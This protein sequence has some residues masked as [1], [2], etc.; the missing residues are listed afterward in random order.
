MTPD[1]ILPDVSP[2]EYEKAGSKFAQAGDHLSECGMPE[3]DTPGVSIKFP[4][5]IVEEGED[6]GKESK[7]SAG[8]GKNALWKLKE[9][10]TALGVKC[11]EVNG[12]VAFD[13]MACVG[14]P[15]V[16]VWT[17]EKDS[18]SPEEGGK[19][20]SYTKPTGALPVGAKTEE[21]L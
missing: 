5:T 20:G 1:I 3:W 6:E 21:L 16:S 14:K 11:K 19:G 17:T 15:F 8:V 13:P 10:L 7:I 9:I 2:E 12:K 4:F 18:R